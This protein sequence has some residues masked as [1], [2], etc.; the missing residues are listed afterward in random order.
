MKANSN[1]LWIVAIALGWLFDFLFFE[2]TPGVNFSIFFV[3]C[4]AGGA[5]ILMGV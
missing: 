3:L 2:H 4:L 5:Y 1:R